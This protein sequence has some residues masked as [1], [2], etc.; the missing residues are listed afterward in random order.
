[1]F[2]LLL[3]P[4]D[5]RLGGLRFFLFMIYAFTVMKF[6][7]RTVFATSHKLCYVKFP[8]SLNIS[9][10]SWFLNMILVFLNLTLV[11]G[12][13]VYNVSWRM[14]CVHLRLC[15]LLLLD[16]LF[17]VLDQFIWSSKSYTANVSLL[18]LSDDLSFDESGVLKQPPSILNDEFP[19]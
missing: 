18:N 2:I 12:S 15:I 4:W 10:L 17:Y 8:F 14:F 16:G 3:V 6:P 13:L 1:M 5:V 9:Y 19:Q 7:F 11:C